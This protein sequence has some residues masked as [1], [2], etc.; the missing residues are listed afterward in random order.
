M[1]CYNHFRELFMGGADKS[2]ET[3]LLASGTDVHAD[4]LKVGRH[5][6]II[7]VGRHN[8]FGHPG[9]STLVTLKHAGPTIYH[10]DQS[11]SVRW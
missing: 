4:F 9:P 6:A 11:C 3:R 1:L 5:V 10:T 2:S 8:T 7:S